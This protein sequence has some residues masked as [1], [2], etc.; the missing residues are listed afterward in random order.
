MPDDPGEACGVVDAPLVF[1]GVEKLPVDLV[2]HGGQIDLLELFALFVVPPL[3]VLDRLGVGRDARAVEGHLQRR[4]ELA[5]A[6]LGMLLQ[7]LRAGL[8]PPRK[9]SVVASL[10]ERVHLLLRDGLEDLGD[11]LTAQRP[12]VRQ[13]GAVDPFFVALHGAALRAEGVDRKVG[14]VRG[15]LLA[16][17]RLQVVEDP[18]RLHADPRRPRAAAVQDAVAFILISLRRL[19]GFP[20]R[21]LLCGAKFCLFGLVLGNGLDLLSA[22]EPILPIVDLFPFVLGESRAEGLPQL[23]PLIVKQTADVNPL[24]DARL[25]LFR[26][27]LAVGRD[28]V[29]ASGRVRGRIEAPVRVFLSHN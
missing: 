26:H 13:P 2:A 22:E 23:D 18:A 8:A 6:K 1:A 29:H 11:A 7:E 25:T 5:V 17:G 16:E 10:V 3:G 9:R 4:Q 24:G 21:F 14:E 20:L 12:R 27:P 19:C 28:D 15:R